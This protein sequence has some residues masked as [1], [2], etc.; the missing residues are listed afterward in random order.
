MTRLS[1]GP[2]KKNCFWSRQNILFFKQ[3]PAK[4]FVSENSP[5]RD[6][7]K[8]QKILQGPKTNYFFYRDQNLN[9]SYL[10]GRV[11]YL[12]LFFIYMLNE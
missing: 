10:Q 12:S 9:G 8:K 7:F 6:Y 5:W 2:C 11:Q 3:V 4:K 1:F